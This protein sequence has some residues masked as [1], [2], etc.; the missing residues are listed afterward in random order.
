MTALKSDLVIISDIRKIVRKAEILPLLRPYV[1]AA[2]QRKKRTFQTMSS[3][4]GNLI[5]FPVQYLIYWHLWNDGTDFIILDAHM[6]S[7]NHTFPA[8]E[9]KKQSRHCSLCNQ[10]LPVLHACNLEHIPTDNRRQMNWTWMCTMY[11][12]NT[13]K[14]RFRHG[15]F[16]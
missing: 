2:C 10:S 4:L 5:T 3:W 14:W 8:Q 12:V 15:H 16:H 11:E 1:L 9:E 13:D 6:F 7:L